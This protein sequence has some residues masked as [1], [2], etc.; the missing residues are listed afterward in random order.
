MEARSFWKCITLILS[1]LDL[2][3]G[4]TWIQYRYDIVSRESLSLIREMGGE[5]VHDGVIVPFPH[6]TYDDVF[7]SQMDDKIAFIRETTK[8]IL[9]LYHG[10]LDA[11]TWDRQKLTEFQIILHRQ[12]VELRKCVQPRKRNR[13]LIPYFKA[14]NENVLK[15]KTYSAQA[16]E[17][18][19]AQV[20]IHLQR[21]NVLAASIRKEMTSV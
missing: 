5:L 13:I 16:W 17:I 21:L 3:L 20:R 10:N 11:V 12:A 14:L 4:C 7:H 18:I 6:K 1:A 19:R 8:Q 2:T 15:K 9:K